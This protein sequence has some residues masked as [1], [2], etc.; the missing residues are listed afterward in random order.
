MVQSADLWW[1]T[2][3]A[4]VTASWRT[5]A[6][7]VSEGDGPTDSAVR[8]AAIAA[9]ASHVLVL[10]LA[11]SIDHATKRSREK[12]RAR[13]SRIAEQH[14]AQPPT[15]APTPVPITT[16][17]RLFDRRGMLLYVGVSSNPGR[18]ITQHSGSKDWWSQVTTTTMEHFITRQMALDA[19]RIAIIT[20]RPIHN[21]AGRPR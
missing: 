13:Q 20:E 10:A 1:Q 14:R 18:R 8:V 3:S 11:R 4:R 9:V 21:I 5:F 19:E 6:D 15:P 12:K 7:L 16:L 17:Y 2:S